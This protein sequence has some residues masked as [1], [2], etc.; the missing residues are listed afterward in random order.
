MQPSL[1]TSRKILLTI[2]LAFILLAYF[3][4]SIKKDEQVIP[5]YSKNTPKITSK[6]KDEP[7]E[8]P[9]V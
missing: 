7:G 3:G 4:V 6:N 8:K 2:A 1:R 5:K 9:K